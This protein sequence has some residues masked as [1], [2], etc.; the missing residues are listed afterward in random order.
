MHHAPLIYPLIIFALWVVWGIYWLISARSNKT[1]QQR[2]SVAS[3]WAHIIPLIVGGVLIAW[4]RMP[5]PLLT[6]RLWPVTFTSYC[7]GIALLAGGLLF[8][9]W[10]R[11]HIGRNW[12]GT[13]TVKED[14]ELIRSG[15]YGL[16]R[17][18]IYTGILTA[19]IG[20]VLISATGRALLGLLIIIIAL[21]RKLR[22]EEAFMR[23]TFP[24]QYERYVAEVPQLIPFTKF[25]RSAQ[26]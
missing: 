22:V 3:R 17:H 21:L 19:L 12:S 10:A 6:H 24:G 4:R 8:S 7:I 5:W 13:V 2:E 16:V 26:R 20:T 11:V 9:V 18:P 14:H 23:A 15:P 25:R 1:T